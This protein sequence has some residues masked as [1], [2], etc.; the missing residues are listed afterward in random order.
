MK[1]SGIFICVILLVPILSFSQ[2][3]SSCASPFSIPMDSISRSY[4]ISAS[5]GSNVVCSSLGTS[6]VTYFSLVANSSAQDMV[7]KITGP[8]TGWV[9]VAFYDGTSCTNGNLE[10]ESSICLYDGTG[11]WSP[12]ENFVITPNQ[13]YILRI[14][15]ATTG[16]LTIQGYYHTPPN[17]SCATAMPIGTILTFDDN[18]AHKPATGISPVGACVVNFTNTALYTY[19]V[20]Y[21]GPTSI[22][23]ENLVCDNH[24]LGDGNNLGFQVGVFKGSCAGLTNVACYIGVPGT[25]QFSGGTQ[26]AG[27]Q[28]Y[29]TINGILSSNC[30]YGI[31]AIN[32]AV[33]AADL[34]YFTAFRSPDGNILKWVSLKEYDNAFF[35]IE[36]SVDG[37][38]FST[39]DRIAGQIN[40]TSEKD[41]QYLDLSPPTKSYYRLKMITRNGRNSYS[42]IIRIDRGKLNSKITFNNLVTDQIALQISNL[43]QDRLQIKIIDQAGREIYHQTTK[44]NPDNSLVNINTA[45]ISK[46]LYY[47]ILSGVD[48]KEAFPFVKF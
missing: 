31:R 36:R 4:T 38:N 15:T 3:G 9:E 24:Y 29:I 14:K 46:G 11:L 2:P 32:A 1:R 6:P 8:N 40:S 26:T 43:T 42:N 34:K 10:T 13:T 44:I 41:Y 37:A 17:N 33:L 20:D 19:T 27:T 21:T 25:Y 48:Y 22:S 35:E 47:I 7:L 16:S 5:T 28:M 18:A 30:E 23:L 39:I 45:T 12:S